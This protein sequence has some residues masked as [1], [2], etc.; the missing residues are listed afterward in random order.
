MSLQQRI[1][2]IELAADALIVDDDVLE[3]VLELGAREGL[4][5]DETLR[6]WR[7]AMRCGDVTQAFQNFAMQFYADSS[8][9]TSAEKS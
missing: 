5:N 6:L 9:A 7:R 1:E 8:D 3:L 2:L 4:S